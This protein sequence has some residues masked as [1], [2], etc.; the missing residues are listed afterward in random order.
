MGWIWTVLLNGPLGLAAWWTARHGFRQPTGL[1]AGLAAAVV[2]W[3]WLT[4]GME[5]LGATGHVDRPSLLAWSLAGLLIAGLLRWRFP[6]PRDGSGEPGARW[7]PAATVA[8][9][10][11][12][13]TAL[14]WG[15][16]SW[17]LPVKVISD[18]PIYHLY[19]AARWWKAGR[20]F[21]VAVPFGESAAT[22]FPAGG[23]L[24]FTWLLTGFGGDRLARVGQAPFLILAGATIVAT[25]RRLGVGPGPAI[26]A[27]T[28]ALTSLP[29]LLFSFEA[30]VD[31]IF[32]AG[33][34]LACYFGLRHGL[35]DG[36][37]PVLVLAGLAAGLAWGTKPT[38]TVFIPPLL[39][40]GAAIVLTRPAP[41]RSRLGR[42]V[43]LLGASLIPSGFWFARN[44]ILT[45][46]PLYPLRVAALGRVW[47]PGWY[48]RSAMRTSPYYI[49]VGDLAAC[50][51]T[52]LMVLDPRLAPFWALALAG[53]WAIGRRRWPEDRWVWGFAALALG[54][55]MLNW[56]L[57]PYRT[58]QRF[59]LHALGLAAVPL[60]RMLDRGRWLTWAGV[61]LLAVHL[62]TP[63]TW[64]FASPGARPFWDLS[65][66]IPTVDQSLIPISAMAPGTLLALGLGSLAVA[67]AWA[68]FAE[69]PTG[70]RALAALLV[71]ALVVVGDAAAVESAV[72]ASGRTF[73]NFPDFARGWRALERLSGPRGVRVAY[74]GTDIPYYLMGG[75]LRND[76]R[77]VNVDGQRDWLLH[78]YHRAARAR[79]DPEPWP[80][81]RPGWDR[82]HPDYE[83]WWA[84]LRASRIDL[85]V[86]ARAN[87]AEGP[88]NVA[89]REGF[90]IERGWAEA[91][92]GVFEAV[93]GVAVP[94]PQLKIYRI[95]RDAPNSSTERGAARH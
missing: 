39:G 7:G 27:T 94:D 53:A 68:R 66:L 38:A 12:I 32:I 48:G 1:P 58:Q 24:W 26:V 69:R 70:R 33:Y 35:G 51:D 10:L 34:L 31:T 76:V 19:F 84:N 22:Y 72:G 20:V 3:S 28:W 62:A 23:D 11:T 54:N 18:A 64:P 87:P 95:R 82:L 57:I 17:L 5:A 6:A 55:L 36:G 8:L 30:N 37:A 4:V 42:L 59:M 85:L 73:P 77:Y 60:A 67:A 81:A 46:N 47:L 80:T 89:D 83:G 52:L 13:G 93:Y 74:A 65:P 71:S 61:A 40:L 79:G 63:P 29:L 56:V 44:A 90:P 78:D 88:F 43:A 21:L 49:P 86:V 92:P 14:I 45:G 41:W 75:G 50:S 91:H 9:G 15:V 2:A 25:A 16:P